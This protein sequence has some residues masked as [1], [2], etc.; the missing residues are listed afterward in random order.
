MRARVKYIRGRKARE[1]I[2]RVREVTPEPV[3]VPTPKK[4][5]G[6]YRRRGL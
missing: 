2:R 4:V 5:G 1:K 3:E 6:G